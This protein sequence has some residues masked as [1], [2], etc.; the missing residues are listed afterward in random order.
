MRGILS[1][2]YFFTVPVFA[3][4]EVDSSSVALYGAVPGYIYSVDVDSSRGLLFAGGLGGV[5]I[6]DV[7]DPATP[8]HLSSIPFEVVLDVSVNGNYLLVS[9]YEQGLAIVDISDASHPQVLSTLKLP[10]QVADVACGNGNV[11]FM[12][13]R[14]AGIFSIDISNPASPS[15][16]DT[17]P[18]GVVYEIYVRNDT[19]FAAG[20]SYDFFILDASNPSSLSFVSGHTSGFFSWATDLR[21]RGDTVFLADMGEGLRVVDVSNPS[22]PVDLDSLDTYDYVQYLDIGGNY[23]YLGTSDDTLF[24]VDLATMSIVGTYVEEG[25]L[26][27]I[28]TLGSIIYTATSSYGVRI[29]DASNP[30][31]ISE[32][33]RFSTPSFTVSLAARDGYAYAGDWNSGLTV[34]DI[35]SPYNP[36]IV[37]SFPS[38]DFVQDLYIDGDYLYVAHAYEGLYVVNIS[39]PSSAF[40][41]GSYNTQGVADGVYVSGNY[42]YVADNFG[43]LVILDI[44]IPQVPSLINT[45]QFPGRGMDVV[46]KDSLLFI[47]AGDSGLVVVDVSD[48]LSPSLVSQ[49]VPSS[50]YIY[51]SKVYLADTL[52]FLTNYQELY[53]LSVSDPS[54]PYV[55]AVDSFGGQQVMDVNGYNNLVYITVWDSGMRVI[56]LN[57][58]DILSYA[59]YYDPYI[60][61]F[62]DGI[63]PVDSFVVISAGIS[64]VWVFRTLVPLGMKEIFQNSRNI[65]FSVLRNGIRILSP[66]FFEIYDA[67]GRRVLGGAS[68][69]FTFV[70]LKRGVYILRMGF[71]R[72]KFVVP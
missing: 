64:G 59:G 68:D 32:A 24:V 66:G 3:W 71:A 58:P 30:S 15:V 42:A 67:A 22:N 4:A 53:I 39:D 18:S 48:P 36:R 33:G 16:L 20:G 1:Y 55:V 44:S 65:R 52:L 7:S 35:S 47:A 28:Q 31:S 69:G 9:A 19:V 61:S 41:D 34:L 50:S 8:V 2:L 26:R 6:V 57:S 21:V 40:I 29:L 43:D 12:A 62:R 17:F 70:P 37:K 5:A 25:D 63:A 51:S 38:L 46:G 11:V 72:E 13:S 27:D 60:S 54:S 10:G 56:D 45:F 23:A 49:F 14:Y